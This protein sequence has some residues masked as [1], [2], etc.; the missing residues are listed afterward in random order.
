MYIYYYVHLHI[1][2]VPLII[3]YMHLDD[4]IKELIRDLPPHLIIGSNQLRILNIILG[5][6][7]HHY[8]IACIMCAC[9]NHLFYRRVWD[10]VQSTLGAVEWKNTQS[11]GC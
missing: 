7:I 2:A 5:Q 8:S 11:G 4:V 1:L 6:G 9:I 10:S 3:L